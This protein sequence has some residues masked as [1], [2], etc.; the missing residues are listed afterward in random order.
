[1]TDFDLVVS[2]GG[3]AG[4]ATAWRAATNGARVLVLD[5]ATFPRD[6]PC[7][8]GLTPRAVKWLCDMGLEDRLSRFHRVDAVRL[9]VGDR[10]FE[11]PWPARE[12][13]YPDHGYVA[14]REELD[15]MLLEHAA[16]A[17]AEVRQGS[18]VLGP[19]V[20]NGVACGVRYRADGREQQVGGD[21]VVAADGM[22][23]RVGRALDMVPLANR[24]FAIAV[25][26]QVDTA[27]AD[28]PVLIVYP[29]LY[30]EGRL[31]PGYGWVFPMGNGKLNIGVGYVSTYRG[32]R[33]IKINDL[34]ADFMRRLP[35]EWEVP[36]VKE[37][38]A[39]RSLKGWRLPMGLAVWPP[40]RP[41]ALAVGD[42][43]GVVKP[44]TGVGISKALECGNLAADAAL[45]ALASGGPQDLSNYE[46]I[47]DRTWGAHYRLGRAFVQV[48]GRPSAMKAFLWAGTRIAPITDFMP[49]LLGNLYR[50][51]GGRP[52]DYIMRSA[53]RLAG[54]RPTG[55]QGGPRQ[56]RTER[57]GTA[58][59]RAG[60]SSK[61]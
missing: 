58:R 57:R 51:K 25:R 44:F 9:V 39:S 12:Y 14:S 16:S 60:A 50:V 3:P 40:W 48:I 17:G 32:Y 11:G 55:A 54:S 56:A 22:S 38:I 45:Q 26:A 42:A 7:G 1:M 29:D 36:S 37:M 24:P 31:I 61:R 49:H 8:D 43:A 41:G 10:T 30:H 19:I 15:D 33:D 20:E 13:G 53:M 18:E 27:S 4:S 34:M 6:K 5:K 2:G 46:R 47:I 59:E 52:G 23:S 28:E 21:I 35:P